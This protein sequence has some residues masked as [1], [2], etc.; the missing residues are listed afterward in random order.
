MP[1]SCRFFFNLRSLSK[2]LLFLFFFSADELDAATRTAK[3]G[4]TA[5]EIRRLEDSLKRLRSSFQEAKDLAVGS[6]EAAA[7]CQVRGGG[8]CT[9]AGVVID[10]LEQGVV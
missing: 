10:A 3:G 8:C 9:C 6:Q 2:R 7:K 4:D 5:G 1:T